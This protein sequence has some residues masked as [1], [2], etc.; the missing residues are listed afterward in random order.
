MLIV[1]QSIIVYGMMIWVMTYFGGIAYKSQYPQGIDGTD[2]YQNKS[3]PFS[4]LL[5][6]SYYFIPIFVFCFFAA[7]R[8]KVGVDCESYKDTFYELAQFG[9]IVS[10]ASEPGFMAISRIVAETTGS[11][12]LL[13]FIL[14]FLQISF[15][16]FAIR[17]KNYATIY[18]GVSIMLS[19]IF[20]SLMNGMRQNIAACM[21]VT[22]IPLVLEKKKWIWFILMTY[23]A[24]T[25]HKSAFLFLPIGILAYFILDK[26]I[27]NIKIQLAIIAICYLLMDKLELSFLD[28]LFSFGEHAGYDSSSIEGYTEYEAMTKNFGFSSWLLLLTKIVCIAYSKRMQ[29]LNNDKTFNIFYNLFFISICINLLFYNNFTIG[30]LNYYFIIFYPVIL[31]IALFVMAHS[32]KKIDRQLFTVTL[33]LLLANFSYNLYNAMSKTIEYTLYKFDLFN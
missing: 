8:F 2:M 32:R 25:I 3:I 20:L 12:Y 33:L 31:S 19:G 24:A 15:L 23:L 7:V 26:G 27:L 9:T 13:F 14:A 1:F 11:H 6:K 28:T 10:G 29:A 16:Y 4:I 30:R 21:L 22:A 5:T 18:L 17:K